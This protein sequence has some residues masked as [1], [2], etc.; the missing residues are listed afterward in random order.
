MLLNRSLIATIVAQAISDRH[1][2]GKCGAQAALG[3]LQSARP[4]RGPISPISPPLSPTQR[5][6]QSLP[7]QPP[8]CA[9][10]RHRRQE[11][12]TVPL[13]LM[14]HARASPQRHVG[15]LRLS[16]SRASATWT[17][18]CAKSLQRRPAPSPAMTRWA[19]LTAYASS[20]RISDR[21]NNIYIDSGPRPLYRI[22]M[23]INTS[24]LEPQTATCSAL[25]FAC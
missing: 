15:A 5:L 1:R 12:G 6:A 25:V 22:M 13:P 14:N 19:R 21:E 2:C 23:G 3:L 16:H 24:T 20:C 10:S 7:N 8:A 18:F 17:T 9:L 11:H 4:V